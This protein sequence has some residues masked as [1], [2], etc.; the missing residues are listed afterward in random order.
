MDHMLFGSGISRTFD[1]KKEKIITKTSACN[2]PYTEISADE[3]YSCMYQ[4]EWFCFNFL[5]ILS[6]IT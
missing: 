5:V 2:K 4:Y 3:A 6:K 1:E